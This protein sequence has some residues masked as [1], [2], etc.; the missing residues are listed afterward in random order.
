MTQSNVMSLN[1][2]TGIPQRDA[3][4]VALRIVSMEKPRWF[5]HPHTGDH[6]GII[7]NHK[8]NITSTEA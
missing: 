6:S 4:E 3:T 7:L 1:V 2:F 5:L 8:A